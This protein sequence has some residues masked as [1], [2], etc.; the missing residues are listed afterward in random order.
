LVFLPVVAGDPRVKRALYELEL[1]RSVCLAL[2]PDGNV[3]A[4][5]L[6]RRIENIM[7]QSAGRPLT[8]PKRHMPALRS[9]WWARTGRVASS[10]A[11]DW[12]WFRRVATREKVV[13]YDDDGSFLI[14]GAHGVVVGNL[15]A[16]PIAV[17]LSLHDADAWLAK[18]RQ[19]LRGSR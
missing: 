4:Q 18:H 3:D 13:R 16:A 10:D 6:T 19:W 7:F 1:G 2:E 15:H 8:R 11:P 5:F 17:V 9:S 14:V 12:V